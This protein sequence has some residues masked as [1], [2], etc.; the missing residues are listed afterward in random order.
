MP[1]IEY[2]EPF[3]NHGEWILY[4]KEEHRSESSDHKCRY[5]FLHATTAELLLRLQ[6]SVL[7]HNERLTVLEWDDYFRRKGLID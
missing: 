6:G 7:A 3:Q 4:P 1:T 5:P 2:D